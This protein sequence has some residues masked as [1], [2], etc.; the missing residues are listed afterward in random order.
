MQ[1]ILK[2][3]SETKVASRSLIRLFSSDI[4]CDIEHAQCSITSINKTIYVLYDFP[5]EKT[6]WTMSN[7]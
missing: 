7:V 2:T 1:R 5:T 3:R 4:S 6:G